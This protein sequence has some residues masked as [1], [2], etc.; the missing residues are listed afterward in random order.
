MGVSG[1]SK[2]P[3]VFVSGAGYACAPLDGSGIRPDAR[4][5]GMLSARLEVA[6]LP[7]ESRLAALARCAAE[8]ALDAAGNL[9]VLEPAEKGVYVSTSKGGIEAFSGESPELGPFLERYVSGGPGQDLR[10][11]LG[12][13]GPGRNTPLACATG[14]YSIGLA[15]EDMRLGR[16]SAAIAGAAEA[17]LTPLI[18]AAFGR[19]GAL[20]SAR[21][22]ED[23]RGPFDRDRAGFV[24]G[25]AGAALVLESE[26][27]LKRTGH[28][29]L[30]EL[31]GWACTC[32]AWHL[33]APLP[34]GEQAARCLSEALKMAGLPPREV[35]YLNAHGTG[36][37]AGDL[38]EAA[39]LK[40]VFGDALP[41]ISSIK[42]ATGHTLGASGAL[43][44]AVTVQALAQGKLP[45]NVGCRQAMPEL[46]RALVL[47]G[48]SLKGTVAV[49]LNM[50]FGGHNVAL[51]FG[52]A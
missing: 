15:F 27:S 2:G 37:L 34:G 32:D 39:A 22:L 36:T 6:P 35:A 31:K 42:G 3:R 26:A 4:L 14:A 50:G 49:S 24:L 8:R 47:E 33:T 5:G 12:W 30:A 7:G 10:A 29:P 45:A 28:R 44:A 11:R 13:T 40:R 41:R 20:T 46:A 18:A 1:D 38:A 9:A 43:E 51:V 16:I 21:A 52:R 48:E 23:Y 17:S 25:E 19:L